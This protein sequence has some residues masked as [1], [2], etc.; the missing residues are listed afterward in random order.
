MVP[1]KIRSFEDALEALDGPDAESVASVNSEPFDTS[2]RK[3]G[4]CCV[5]VRLHGRNS[6][7]H[8]AAQVS[9]GAL[10]Y[11]DLHDPRRYL[12]RMIKQRNKRREERARAA[13]ARDLEQQETSFQDDCIKA[14]IAIAA[15]HKDPQRLC[16]GLV[17]KATHLE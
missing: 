16:S 6:Q 4:L 11:C 2:D 12:N 1:K 9:Y 10:E 7:C 13:A 5:R 17:A 15:G 3:P 14:V 8:Q